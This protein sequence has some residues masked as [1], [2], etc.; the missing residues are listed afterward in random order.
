MHKKTQKPKKT[1]ES[2]TNL[3]LVIVKVEKVFRMKQ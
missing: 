2:K 1:P 3:V